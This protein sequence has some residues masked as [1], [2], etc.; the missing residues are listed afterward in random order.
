MSGRRLPFFALVACLIY[1]ASV[2]AQSFDELRRQMREGFAGQV[3]QLSREYR[4]Y[5]D[6]VNAEFARCLGRP[7]ESVDRTDPGTVAPQMIVPDEPQPVCIDKESAQEWEETVVSDSLVFDMEDA[8]LPQ[9]QPVVPMMYEERTD[10]VALFVDFFNSSCSVRFDPSKKTGLADTSEPSVM[11]MWQNL[12]HQDYDNVVSDCLAIRDRLSLC[13]W[14][15]LKLTEAVAKVIY[16]SPSETDCAVVL[17][18]FLMNQS[19][20][21]IRLGRDDDRELHLLFAA[22]DDMMGRAYWNYGG[23]HYYL[24]DDSGATALVMV[25]ASFPGEKSVRLLMDKPQN[26]DLVSSP[27]RILQ[28]ERYEKARTLSSVNENQMAFW[29]EY[30]TPYR[31][32]STKMTWYYYANTPISEPVKKLFYPGLQAS[33]EGKTQLEAVNILLNFV[34]TAFEYRVDSKVWGDERSFYP[35]ETLFYQYSDCEDR[36]I[37]FSRIIR[38]L[39]GLDVLLVY[40]PNHLATAVCMND[41]CQGDKL[42]YKD[43]KYTI[44]DP[45][46]M[47]ASAGMTMQDCDNATADIIVL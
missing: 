43:R 35:E 6:K 18:A 31:N 14:G 10:Q 34:Q 5:R 17:Q 41:D 2:S 42:I 47:N 27:E 22:A 24:A 28:A 38:D 1:P 39:L 11:A 4:E 37:L 44:C 36:A 13:D 12:S 32:L 23:V 40:Y 25:K 29:S 8:V 30:P 3:S 33:I 46:Y 7:W 20:Y 15:Y 9:P 26:L 19:G 16:D 45:T 21:M